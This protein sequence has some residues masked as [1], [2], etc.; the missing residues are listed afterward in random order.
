M[1]LKK[2]NLNELKKNHHILVV[3]EQKNLKYILYNELLQKYENNVII[4]S[5]YEKNFKGL[6]DKKH[7]VYNKYTDD[8]LK[9]MLFDSKT[10]EKLLILDNLSHII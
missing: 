10:E 6:F 1:E 4:I 2:L 7:F 5:P 8:I 3:G 9:K